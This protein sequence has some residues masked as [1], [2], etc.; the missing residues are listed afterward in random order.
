MTSLEIDQ[1]AAMRLDILLM[2]LDATRARNLSC[3][4]YHRPTTPNLDGFSQR[5]V[6]CETAI[7]PA[8]WSLPSHASMFT[9]LYLSTH[10]ADDQYHSLLPE[11]PT[12][13][14]L[15]RS[16][17]YHMLALCRR[18][19][20]DPAMALDRGFERSSPDH[21][22]GR[23]GRLTCWANT[24]IAKVLA[25]HDE[26]P[27]YT[28][29]QIYKL[30]PRRHADGRPFFICVSYVE[31][32]TPYNP[33]RKYNHHLPDGISPKRVRVADWRTSLE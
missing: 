27:Q 25:R 5:C 14:E 23:V 20:V 22:P 30:L 10:G 17:G 1:R 16:Y 7:S 31:S 15:L 18:T 8:G 13:A 21:N 9:G 4:G 6:V 12:M 32:H 2:V 24:G 3:Y 19:D 33:P 11:Y 28:N 26:G 29:R